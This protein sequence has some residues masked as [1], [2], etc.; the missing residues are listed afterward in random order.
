MSKSL[1]RIVLY[2]SLS[3]EAVIETVRQRLHEALHLSEPL[4]E[5]LFSGQPVVI[6]EGITRE[7]ALEHKEMIDATGAYCEIEPVTRM[8]RIDTAGFIE[9]REEDERR[10]LAD[11]RS[12]ERANEGRRQSER[13]KQKTL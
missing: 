1:Y 9:R 12:H 7:Q 10:A 5:K 4:M 13:R 8:R 3:D 6:R 11:R 2:C